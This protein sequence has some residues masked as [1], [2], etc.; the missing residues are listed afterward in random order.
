MPDGSISS[1]PLGAG[2]AEGDD[3]TRLAVV[4]GQLV[5]GAQLQAGDLS[6]ATERDQPDGLAHA[7]L[8]AHRRAR[9]DVQTEALGR[10]V[11]EG[12]GRVGVGEVQVGA[13]LDRSVT[14]VADDEGAGLQAGVELDRLVGG[15]PDLTG[16]HWIGSVIVTSL[17]PS[18]KVASTWTSG[19]ISGTP[20]ITSSRERT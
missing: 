19:T 14:V 13:D 12:Q 11:V 18:G 5:V 6:A 3:R 9:G 1:S 10:L 7:G 20:S 4:L 8:E 15:G 16:D 2:R 17:R